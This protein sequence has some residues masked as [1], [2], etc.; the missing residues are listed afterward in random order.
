MACLA[1]AAQRR[2]HP[3]KHHLTDEEPRPNTD[4]VMQAL[5]FQFKREARSVPAW[6][7]PASKQVI[8]TRS[9]AA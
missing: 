6:I 9:C 8:K 1:I 4:R 7:A 2:R 5:I 3:V